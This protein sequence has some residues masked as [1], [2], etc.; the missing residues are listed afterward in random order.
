M[1]K[2]RILDRSEH[3]D[4]EA[5]VFVCEDGDGIGQTFDRNELARC[6]RVVLIGR[7][8]ESYETSLTCLS[9]LRLE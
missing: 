8:G 1:M 5:Y 3:C 2:I 6:V 7:G 4:G 9:A